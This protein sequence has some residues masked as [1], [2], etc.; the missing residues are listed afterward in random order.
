MTMDA[1][2]TVI[3]AN[4]NRFLRKRI[5]CVQVFKGNAC[6]SR[7][8]QPADLFFKGRRAYGGQARFFFVGDF[9][10]SD[11]RTGGRERGTQH[12]CRLNIG[13]YQFQYIIVLKAIDL[14]D[15]RIDNFSLV[16]IQAVP[17]FRTRCNTLFKTHACQLPD[18]G[19]TG[20]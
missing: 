8:C 3:E 19:N 7:F 1:F 10:I 12:N 11:D 6:I 20:V 17:Y 9:M 16:Q 2:I 4:D 14:R 13:F 5:M 15:L 18:I